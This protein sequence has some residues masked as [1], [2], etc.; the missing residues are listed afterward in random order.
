[1][2]KESITLKEVE[3]GWLGIKGKWVADREQILAAWELYVELVT[4]IAVQ[5]LQPGQG[6]L[7]EALASLYALFAETR[8]ILK[9][10]GPGVATAATKGSLSLGLIAVKVLNQE[11]RPVLSQWHPELQAH[12]QRRPAD[13]SPLAHE[14]AWARHDEMRNVLEGVRAHLEQYADLLAIVAGIQ[15]LK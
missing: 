15:P 3:I 2:A 9:T 1:M 8:R 7:R 6:L 13:V 10:H 5:P 12:E 4:R 14:R 11:L